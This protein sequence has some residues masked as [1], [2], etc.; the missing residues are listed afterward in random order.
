MLTKHPDFLPSDWTVISVCVKSNKHRTDK[1]ID[2]A[3][4]TALSSLLR[5]AST[6]PFLAVAAASHHFNEI[7]CKSPFNTIFLKD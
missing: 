7:P 3:Y 6:S 5:D 2:E 1:W 4:F